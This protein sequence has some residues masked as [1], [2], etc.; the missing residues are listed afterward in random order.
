ML[1]PEQAINGD[2]LNY[3]LLLS[4]FLKTEEINGIRLTTICF[5]PIL[6]P[7]SV[8]LFWCVSSALGALKVNIA[9]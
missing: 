7:T 9:F 2:Y 8:P 6:P 1:N 3:L 5:T 4:H